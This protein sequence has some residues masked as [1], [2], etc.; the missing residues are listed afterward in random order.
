MEDETLADVVL[1]DGEEELTAYIC[2]ECRHEFVGRERHRCPRC[3]SI[4]IE[5][6]EG[7][8]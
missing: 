1:D 7:E 2:R 8:L 6:R 3:K 5:S 4:V